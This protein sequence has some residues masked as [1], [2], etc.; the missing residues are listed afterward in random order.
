MGNTGENRMKQIAAMVA[1]ACLAVG[2]QARADTFQPSHGCSRP[3]KPCQFNSQWELD[4][5]E[6]EVEDYK[7]CISDFVEEQNEAVR[8]HRQAA[9]DAIDE[10]NR[11]VRHE[12]N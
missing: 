7:R 3:Y 6:D 9:E 10:W 1:A 11:N 8:K 4:R 2:F 5:F 12:L